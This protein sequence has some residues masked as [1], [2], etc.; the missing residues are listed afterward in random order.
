VNKSSHNKKLRNGV[1]NEKKTPTWTLLIGILFAFATGLLALS[2]YGT[3]APVVNDT[4]DQAGSSLSP[5]V[6]KA[7]I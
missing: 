5:N 6:E 4:V 7:G 2:S 3:S 1:T